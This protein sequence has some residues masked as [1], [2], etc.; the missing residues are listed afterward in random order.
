MKTEGVNNGVNMDR[1]TVMFSSDFS[2]P[3]DDKSASEV[4][5]HSWAMVTML[6]K[7]ARAQKQWEV[8]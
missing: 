1:G 2:L 4:K 8:R 5:N 7:K 6:Q 3:K